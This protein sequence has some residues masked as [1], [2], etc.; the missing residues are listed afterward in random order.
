MAKE[1]VMKALSLAL[2]QRKVK[3]GLL[4]HSDRGSQYTSKAFQ[5]KLK[6]KNIISSMSRKGN[7]WD[8]ACS[9]SFFHTLKTEEVNGK[10]YST[11][12]EAH[13]KIFEYIESFYNRNRLHSSIGYLTPVEFEE[14]ML[15]ME[16]AA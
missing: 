7:C 15:L 10:T 5:N 3:G 4:F 6:N 13:L 16:M 9:E 8:N 12:K 11:R 14:K 2:M 1:L